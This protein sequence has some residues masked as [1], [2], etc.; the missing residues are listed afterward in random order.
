MMTCPHCGRPLVEVDNPM[1]REVRHRRG[2]EATC[3]GPRA[4]SGDM[5]VALPGAAPDLLQA[6]SDSI[7][8]ARKDRKDR[9][10]SP[11]PDTAPEGPWTAT[12]TYD[13][14]GFNEWRIE[15]EDACLVLDQWCGTGD[16]RA[17]AERVAAALNSAPTT[18]AERAVIDAAVTWYVDQRTGDSM[19]LA[20]HVAKLLAERNKTDG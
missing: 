5:A 2:E 4:E 8:D 7:R 9:A 17:E 18:P 6:L 16:G 20:A 11:Q 13:R 12:L 15:S 14:E 10:A 1:R 3:P 19:A